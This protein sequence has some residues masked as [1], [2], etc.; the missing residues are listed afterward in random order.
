[1][2]DGVTSVFSDDWLLKPVLGQAV[3]ADMEVVFLFKLR[4]RVTVHCMIDSLKY[5]RSV[6]S[7]EPPGDVL[8]WP[9]VPPSVVRVKLPGYAQ[10][11]VT[12]VLLEEGESPESLV[13]ERSIAKVIGQNWLLAKPEVGNLFAFSCDM[14]AADSKI[15][16]WDDMLGRLTGRPTAC[17]HLGDQIYGDSVYR[18]CMTTSNPQPGMVYAEYSKLYQETWSPRVELLSQTW[19]YFTADDHEITNDIRLYH[20]LTDKETVV[21]SAAWKAYLDYQLALTPDRSKFYSEFSYK[22]WLG[23]PN[24]VL[25]FV[26][27]RSSEPL[28]IRRLIAAMKEAEDSFNYLVLALPCAPVIKP[29]GLGSSFIRDDRYLEPTLAIELYEYLLSLSSPDCSVILLGGDCHYGSHR[30]IS[31]GSESITVLTCSPI[32]NQPDPARLFAALKTKDR[33]LVPAGVEPALEESVV[34]CHARKNYAE[35][36][37]SNE[38]VIMHYGGRKPKSIIRYL[39][40]MWSMR[41][42]RTST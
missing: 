3:N 32:T 12:W 2:I 22:T 33:T 42:P 7:F 25:L 28:D 6:H 34:S 26:V 41:K 38:L 35:L 39:R 29:S 17:L 24:D 4:G 18:K 15:S 31:R 40:T 5:P 37:F 23:V 21:A 20:E 19:N 11:S 16:L 36:D 10:Y 8:P 13:H 27:E 9:E 14:P 1:M 30:I